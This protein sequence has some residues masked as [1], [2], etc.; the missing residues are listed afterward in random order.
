MLIK[1]VV[2][3][4]DETLW[5]G[6]LVDGDEPVLTPGAGEVVRELDRRGILQSIASRNDHEPAWARVVAFGLDEFFLHPQICWADKSRSV[7]AVADR[8]GIGLDAVAFVDDQAVERDEV[9]HAL[10]MVTTID[11][12][13]LGGLLGLP[14]MRPRFVT[15]ESR[16]RRTMYVTDEVRKR[17]ESEFP[18]TREEFLATLGMHV[19]IRPAGEPDLRRAEE[20]TVRTHQLNTTGRPYSYEQLCALTRSPDHLLLVAGLTDRYGTSGTVGLALVDRGPHAWLIRLFIT[21]CRVVSRGVGGIMM[22]HIL[23]SAQRRGVSLRAEFVPNDRNRLMYLTYKFHGFREIGTDGGTV[24]LEHDLV[25][26]RPRPRGVTVHTP[27]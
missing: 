21:S 11:A 5:R 26:I 13:D 1:C 24:L 17:D 4:L 9:R 20:L 2:W 18:G 27:G 15:A 7:R 6:T 14:G 22:T 16:I 12:A 10:P 25:H 19:T 8:L 23:E 3:D